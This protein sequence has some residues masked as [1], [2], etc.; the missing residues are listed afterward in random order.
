VRTIVPVSEV[1]GSSISGK[2]VYEITS[3]EEKSRAVEIEP[4]VSKCKEGQLIGR[5]GV[6]LNQG[7]GGSYTSLDIKLGEKKN[8]FGYDIGFFDYYSEY[9]TG[10]FIVTKRDSSCQKGCICNVDGSQDCPPTVI[11]EK[12]EELCPDGVCRKECKP[13]VLEEC[14]FGCLSGDSCLPIG[15]R[16]EGQYCSIDRDLKK[17]LGSGETCENDFECRTNSCLDSAC[18]EPG[19]WQNLYKWLSKIFG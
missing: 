8:V 4:V 12:G 14:K 7:V 11:C 10:V 13:V 16:V 15:I 5:L 17:Q 9:K 2:A 3:S 19:F 6:T 1:V 18:T